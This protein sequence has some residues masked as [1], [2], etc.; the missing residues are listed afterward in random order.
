MMTFNL[1]FLFAGL[2]LLILI[3]YHFGNRKKLDSI[4]SHIFHYFIIMALAD[5]S[6]DIICSLLMMRQSA[7]LVAVTMASLTIFYILQ[8]AMP[9]SLLVYAQTLRNTSMEKIKKDL[10]L[11]FIPPALILVLIIANCWN[12]LLFSIDSSGVYHNGPL[13]MLM[14]YYA[15]LYAGVL[16]LLT[17]VHK[18]ELSKENTAVLWEFLIIEAGCVAIQAYHGEYLMTGFGI[19]VGVTVLFLTIGN[20]NTYVDH[21]TGAFDKRYFDKWFS[22]QQAKKKPIHVVA[23]NLMRLKQV[24]RV[25]G[26]D[27]GDQLLI[28][29]TQ[30]L[31]ELGPYVRVFRIS[32]NSFF[33]TMQMLAD[34]EQ[35]RDKVMNYFQRNF[36]VKGRS[37]P[38]PVTVCGVIHG[39]RLPENTFIAYV[40]YMTSLVKDAK[41]T[42]LIQSDE[43]ILSGFLYEQEI[44]L[45]LS[46]A[47]EKDLFEVYYQPIYS[48]E[49]GRYTTLEALS[50]LWHPALGYVPPDVFI[51]RAEKTG[52]ILQIALLQFRR[53]CRFIKENEQ[54]M[55]QIQ[56]VKFN[57]SPVEI[58]DY[59]H[60]QAL[61]DIIREYGLPFSYFQFE[62]TETVATE[63][64]ARLYDVLDLLLETGVS[65]SLDDFGSGYANLNTVLKLP[66]SCIK[67]DRSLLRGLNEDAQVAFFYHSL[68]SMLHEMN[69]QIVSEGV[70]TEAEKEKLH[71]WG[72]DMIQGYY[73]SRPLSGQD[74][75]KLLTENN[76]LTGNVLR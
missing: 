53:I 63:Y 69:F 22:E 59:G 24:N 38:F 25:F 15:L 35:T 51:T 1:D 47:V 6:F 31:Q 33:L 44:D 45:F 76:E 18:K 71:A 41:E 48:L 73:F 13:Y 10:I 9:L 39:E 67:M 2:T 55:G 21:M 64:S 16:A 40:D 12:G 66:F 4:S 28:E 34:Y 50:R 19:S 36:Q 58:L 61:V 74:I 60:I 29:I 56:N 52:H 20:P 65:L 14:Y 46:E 27:I 3:F 26:D 43:K 72:V 7:A 62:I 17:I 23:V 75:V 57:L 37:T 54:I 5:V 11:W 68:V 49:S 8:L 30:A 32:G 42:V 70:E